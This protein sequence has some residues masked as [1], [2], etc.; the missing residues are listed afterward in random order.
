MDITVYPSKLDGEIYPPLSKSLVHRFFIINYFLDPTNFTYSKNLVQSLSPL[1]SDDIV[2]TL[3]VLEELRLHPHKAQLNFK[4]SG[5]TLRFMIPLLALLGGSYYLDAHDDL[6]KRPLDA[7]TPLFGKVA[8]PGV[9]TSSL[10]KESYTID[11]SVSSQYVSGMLIA[12]VARNT[13]AYL[14]LEKTLHSKPYVDTTL[15]ML[16]KAG[17]KIE[18]ETNK[19]GLL[20]FKIYPSK[21]FRLLTQES[22]ERDWSQA[23]FFLVAKALGASLKVKELNQN[24]LQGDK[25][26]LNFIKELKRPQNS[27]IDIAHTPDLFPILCVLAAHQASKLTSFINIDRLRFKESDRLRSS[28]ELLSSLG[29]RAYYTQNAFFVHGQESFKACT[30]HSYND[31]RI[32][33]AGAIAACFAQGPCKIIKAEA[34]IKSYPQFFKELSSLGAR[35]EVGSCNSH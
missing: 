34:V 6:K 9:F 4:S 13:L 29:V 20:S 25:H 31:H 32:A 16:K 17:A 22:L 27:L 28:Y 8:I 23:A 12:L 7:Y 14:S 15:K 1:L 21:E 10:D 5:S 33:M 26:I 11:P 24:S 19:E 18:L 30:I 35:L 3:D 2:T